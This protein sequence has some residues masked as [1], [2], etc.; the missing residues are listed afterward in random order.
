MSAVTRREFAVAGAVALGG[1]LTGCGSSSHVKATRTSLPARPSPT[2]APSLPYHPFNGGQTGLT[3][4]VIAIKVDNTAPAHPQYGVQ[5]ADIV[6]VEQVEG[7]E[8]RLMAIFSSRLPDRVEP[9]RSARISD[10]HVLA[11]F[12]KPAFAFSGVQ[13][14]M[15]PH[16]A[17][18]SVFDV[19]DNGQRPYLRDDV[20][21]QPYNEYADP[22]KLLALAPQASGPRD[23]GFRFGPAPATGG[24]PMT[25]FTAQWPVETLRWDWDPASGRYLST[26]NS[27]PNTAAEGGRLGAA[28]VV[29][30]YCR[31]TRSEF[32]DFLGSYTPLIQT[33]G[34][35]RATVLRGGT[36]YD[37]TWSRP[38][39]TSGTVFTTTTGERMTFAPGQVWVNLVNDGKPVIP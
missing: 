13:S 22:R 24:R 5:S 30:Q 8:T 23:I 26:H 28:T 32:H 3:N 39:E 17:A 14:K 6:Y 25:T 7:G 20:R 36:A 9:I 34:T 11:Q 27:T 1:V 29:I 31:T 33:T 37:C 35:G 16:V 38:E 10:L 2:P 19:S 18:A 12:G 4:P 21:P 15:K